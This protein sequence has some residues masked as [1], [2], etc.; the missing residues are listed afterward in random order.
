MLGRVINSEND[1]Q[2]GIGNKKYLLDVTTIILF[3]LMW[4]SNDT[5]LFG[6]NSN[7]FLVSLPRYLMLIFCITAL[8]FPLEI[9]FTVE[10]KKQFIAL[11]FMMAIFI[12]VGVVNHEQFNRVVIKLLC[13][14]TG[15]VIAFKIDFEQF[16]KSFCNIIYFLSYFAIIMSIVG[17][18][19]P[20][21]IRMLPCVENTAGV[22]IYT[23]FLAG[24]D[25]RMLD[26]IAV[27]TNGI[28]WEPGV[29]QMYL[30]L[31]LLLEMYVF[32]MNNRKRFAIELIALFFTYSTTG[33]IVF[34]WGLVSYYMFERGSINDIK[35]TFSYFILLLIGVGGLFVVLNFT[36]LGEVVFG[37]VI[38]MEPSGTAVVRMASVFM[39]LEIVRDNPLHGIGMENIQDEFLRRSMAS[40]LFEG[41]TSQNTNTL[42][43]QYAAH[44]ALYGILFTIGTYKFGRRMTDKTLPVVC[45]FIF[46]AL[47]YI[48]ENLQYSFFP[49]VIIFYGYG[50]YRQSNEQVDVL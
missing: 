20:G 48:G 33:Y 31:A 18:I 22:R 35:R 30:N 8:L 14:L 38:N 3:I 34:V 49:F 23:C 17:L 28:Y 21:L 39:N 44:G 43:Y 40:D 9:T 4:C 6:T 26:S 24:I 1:L 37:K 41:W 10:G 32:K 45:I 50:C 2:N 29:Y 47:M 7:L 16:A 12:V 25:E 13:M 42:L 19:A 5:A 15:F 46:F 36:P 27:R 11:L